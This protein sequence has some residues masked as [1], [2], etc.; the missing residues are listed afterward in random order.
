VI[1]VVG[2]FGTLYS[3]ATVAGRVAE[4]LRANGMLAGC[5]NLDEAWHP[6]WAHLSHSPHWAPSTAEATHLLLVT[7]PNHYVAGYA[8]MFGR[9][10]SAIFVSPNTDRLDPEHAA[11]ISNFGLAIAPSRFCAE[12]VANEC[13]VDSM[14]VLSLGSPI[15]STLA[16]VDRA[17]GAPVRA[18]HFTSD[19][20]WPSRKGT[21][22]LLKAWAQRRP[23]PEAIL[24]I[25]GPPSLRKSAL[26]AIADLGIDETVTYEPSGRLGT[27]DE[28]LAALYEQADLI[29]APSRSEG[30][31]MMMLA[32][33]VAGVPLLTTCNTGHAE[34]LNLRPGAWLPIP[35]P[36]SGPLAFESGLAPLVD[37]DTLAEMLSLA[38][39]PFARDWMVKAGP[40]VGEA[41]KP[42]WGSWSLASAQWIERLKEWTEETV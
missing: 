25:H 30:F 17:L 36:H 26:Y 2:H 7:A 10:R 27:S 8:Q 5:Q 20:A 19:Q 11:T 24:T 15:P 34:F 3:Y 38:L 22:T 42:G 13:E 39:T 4:A 9:D 14:S 32:A 6:H 33:L 18:L 23:G 31:G 37:V 16:K 41:A 1:A 21:E 28:E 40:G 35:T 29:V 12:T